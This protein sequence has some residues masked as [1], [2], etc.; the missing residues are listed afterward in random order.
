M[1]QR[2]IGGASTMNWILRWHQK[3]SH[4]FSFKT[5]HGSIKKTE[6]GRQKKRRMTNN[7]NKIKELMEKQE[8]TKN[9]RRLME[10]GVALESDSIPEFVK[11]KGIVGYAMPVLWF[12]RQR[13]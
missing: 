11:E 3:L 5:N 2:N 1:E 7:N 10:T 9:K 13:T 4:F 6:K 8:Q 12:L